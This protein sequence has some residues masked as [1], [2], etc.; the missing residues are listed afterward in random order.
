MNFEL[1]QLSE[2]DGQDI[3]EM[4]RK[5]PEVEHGFNNVFTGESFDEFKTFLEERIKEAKGIDLKEGRV[6]QTIFWFY[7][8]EKPV[9]II[10]LRP[11]LNDA[12]KEH[13]GHM[14]Y[15]V[16]PEERGKGYAT[17][18]VEMAKE[19]FKEMGIDNILITCEVGNIASQKVIEKN[20]GKLEKQ[21]GESCYYWI[22]T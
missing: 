22:E 20:G 7:V 18:M 16:I 10:K 15:T 9:G 12:L 3:Y 11:E 2:D 4:L 5:L 19:K 13:G 21:V 14:G 6:P 8:D 1:K 17:K